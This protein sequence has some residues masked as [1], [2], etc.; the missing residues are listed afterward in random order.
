MR[1]ADETASSYW[2]F[3]LKN[4]TSAWVWLQGFNFPV[5]Y[6]GLIKQ[7]KLFTT[8]RKEILLLDRETQLQHI[9]KSTEP[10]TLSC[11]P[12]PDGCV[13]K[14]WCRQIIPFQTEVPFL[15]TATTERCLWHCLNPSHHRALW[16]SQWVPT[17]L[18]LE[19]CS[20]GNKSPLICNSFFP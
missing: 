7:S 20:P 15:S 8:T 17:Q 14:H 12:V 3:S 13:C 16:A 6:P 4:S 18:S 19:W 2:C 9:R 1:E 5:Q 10:G 11:L